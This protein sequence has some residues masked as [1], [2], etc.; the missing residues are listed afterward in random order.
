MTPDQRFAVAMF[1]C[2]FIGALI[3]ATGAWLSQKAKPMSFKI[4]LGSK[5]R[6]KLNGYTGIVAGRTEWL[7]GCRRYNVQAQELKDGKP[8]DMI[9]ADEDELEV[10]DQAEPH[11][12][13]STGGPQREPSRPRDA[14]R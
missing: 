10:L 6:S 1:A 4:E 7:Y 11:A 5:V 12:V 9:G 13:K 2:L 14:T 8:V 3:G